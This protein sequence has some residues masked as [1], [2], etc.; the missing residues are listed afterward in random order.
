MEKHNQLCEETSKTETGCAVK[1]PQQRFWLTLTK[2]LP[3]K[4]TFRL[5]RMLCLKMLHLKL[6]QEEAFQI[7]ANKKIEPAAR[8]FCLHSA[9]GSYSW[10]EVVSSAF[11]SLFVQIRSKEMPSHQG[12]SSEGACRARSLRKMIN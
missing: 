11:S 5:A 7:S 6:I 8:T 12:A 10:T 1:S 4:H 2:T 3:E 9:V